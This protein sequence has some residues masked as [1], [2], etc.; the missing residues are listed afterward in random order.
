MYLAIVNVVSSEENVNVLLEDE[1][2]CTELLNK[3]KIDNSLELISLEP[4][5]CV[6]LGGF[7]EIIPKVKY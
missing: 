6:D 5:W 7:W 1:D 2:E 4:F 3:I